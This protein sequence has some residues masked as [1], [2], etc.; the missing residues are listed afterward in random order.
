MAASKY[1]QQAFEQ[2]C[3]DA[4]ELIRLLFPDMEP[5]DLRTEGGYINM[6]K[7]RSLLADRQAQEASAPVRCHDR[8][9]CGAGS[10]PAD[11]LVA[12]LRCRYPVC[13]SIRPSGHDWDTSRLDEVIADHIASTPAAAPVQL[14]GD[15]MADGDGGNS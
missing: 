2:E 13:K 10:A 7:V 5:N 8:G 9:E 11:L 15:G 6:P 12:V 1:R 14:A 4:D 3:D